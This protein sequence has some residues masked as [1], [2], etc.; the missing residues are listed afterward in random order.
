MEK[1]DTAGI[2]ER[3]SIFNFDEV[4]NDF[5]GVQNRAVF[6]TPAI[7]NY[8][9]TVL[10][11]A[12]RD[13]ISPM[14]FNPTE[15]I[16]K[17]LKL[18]APQNLKITNLNGV[19][20]KLTWENLNFAEIGTVQIER[21]AGGG[22]YVTVA[23]ISTNTT[24]YDDDVTATGLVKYNYRLTVK[25]TGFTNSKSV[26][27]TIDLNPNILFNV[28]L[29]KN[30]T[31]TSIHSAPYPA[32]SAV[33][34]DIISD[35]SRWVTKSGELP[36]YIEIDLNGTFLIS[37]LKFY[38]GYQGYN[39]I[40]GDFKLEYWNS[41]KWVDLVVETSNLN[42]SYSKSFAEVKTS[43][44][45]LT[46]NSA[47]GGIA[48]F[49]E[50]EVYGKISNTLGL[51]EFDSNNFSIYPNPTTNIL[52][53]SNL[54]APEL[55]EVFDLNAKKLIEKQNSNTVDV[56]QLTTGVYIVKINQKATLQFI[57]K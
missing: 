19:T 32:S 22:G 15:Q 28:A 12:Y 40:I 31:A 20:N 41:D 39:G 24:S 48:R 57:K 51:N 21:A 13:N 8:T 7:P 36:A 52:Y 46:V 34:G 50:I 18:V 42:S 30:V 10:G 11:D 27:G 9:F 49:Y 16:D 37:Q 45:R 5:G 56:S 23:Q 38:S 3:Y 29:K 14:A 26:T 43:K 1:Y 17:S 2:I 47:N 53:I 54:N 55:V 44:V 35:A 33:D 6:V 25:Q 4:V